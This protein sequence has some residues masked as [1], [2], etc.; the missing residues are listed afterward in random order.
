MAPSYDVIILG[1]GLSGIAAAIRLSHYGQ[2]VLL[3]EKNPSRLGGMNSWYERSGR[4]IDT[5][6]HALTNY[7]P[8]SETAAPLNRV[9]RQL[10]LRRAE[11]ALCPQRQ[12]RIQFPNG[13]ELRLI[14][15]AA[16]L[17]RQVAEHFS[18][19]A[20]GYD[21]LVAE[22]LRCGYA[23]GALP[24]TRSANAVLAEHISSARLRDML[25]FPVMYYG[26]ATPEDMPF[27]AFATMF[28]SVLLEGFARPASGMRAF[29]GV[30]ERRLTENGVEIRRGCVAQSILLD[31]DGMACACTTT[32]GYSFAARHILSTIGACETASLLPKG[33]ERH[34]I[35]DAPEGTVGFFEAIFTLPRPPQSYGLEDAIRFLCRTQ[36]FHYAP[37]ADEMCPESMLLCAPGNYVDCPSEES[38]ILRLSTIVDP[39]H[40]LETPPALYRQAKLSL[41]ESLRDFL[42]ETVSPCLAS[43]L[44]LLDAFTPKTILRWTGHENGAI[45][46][47]PM[48]FPSSETGI[49]GLALAG[50]DQ[51]LLGITGSMLSGILAANQLLA[52]N[53]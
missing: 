30:L 36:R 41:A 18:G 12:S 10:R 50:T 34:P 37:P 16:D 49:P 46:G 13:D 53:H 1:G 4:V 2:H 48:K 43:D 6:L 7:V 22:V 33:P 45:Y 31:E 15:D 28:R 51:G 17:R 39:A 44:T 32:D 38:T 52:T 26:N 29:L 47:S 14:N 8:E 35:D 40:W 19:D 20:D 5:A 42:A 27:G 23:G 3:L 9:L 21:A 24:D 11:F 25:R